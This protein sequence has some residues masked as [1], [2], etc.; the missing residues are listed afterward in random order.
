MT[1]AATIRPEGL[2]VLSAVFAALLVAALIASSVIFAI[3]GKKRG[4]DG[5]NDEKRDDG[6]DADAADNACD[7]SR[8]VAEE[9]P[10]VQPR[11]PACTESG[12]PSEFLKDLCAGLP[13]AQRKRLEELREHALSVSGASEKISGSSLVVRVRSK[14]LVKISVRGNAIKATYRAA[15]EEMLAYRREMGIVLP[16][17]IV[18]VY[19]DVSL[20]SAIRMIDDMALQYELEREAAK[21][22]R[23]EKRRAKRNGKNE[24][25][26]NPA[27]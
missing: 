7:G 26:E 19:D 9:Y 17:T 16:D 11:L 2:I 8:S 12:A 14:P 27:R 24:N 10:T 3:L 5:K 21:A 4:C 22:R 6:P 20:A 25:P 15:T 18:R 13:E 1:A 23:R